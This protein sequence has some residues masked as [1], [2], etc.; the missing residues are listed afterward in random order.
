LFQQ[1][2]Y[3]DTKTGEKKYAAWFKGSFLNILERSKNSREYT[4]EELDH[5][6][7]YDSDDLPF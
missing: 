6:E 5:G 3:Q 7:S 2:E 1:D 4:D